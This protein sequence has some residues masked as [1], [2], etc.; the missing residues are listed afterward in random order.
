MRQ[1]FETCRLPTA[2][3]R[4]TGWLERLHARF[5]ASGARRRLVALRHCSPHLLRDIGLSE[6]PQINRLLQDHQLRR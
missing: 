6:R 3:P 2:Q 1:A 5:F 4:Q